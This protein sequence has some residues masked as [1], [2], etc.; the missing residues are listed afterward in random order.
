MGPCGW[1][2]GAHLACFP[3]WLSDPLLFPTTTLLLW[4]RTTYFPKH[5]DFSELC[6]PAEG[7]SM[8]LWHSWEPSSPGLT[9]ESNA[10]GKSSSVM[11]SWPKEVPG[12]W[13]IQ[14]AFRNLRN[15]SSCLQSDFLSV[16]ALFNTC[17]KG[18]GVTAFFFFF[19]YKSFEVPALRGL[20]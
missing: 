5:S 16:F 19:F 4:L 17:G 2:Q 7:R 13:G 14:L 3:S 8:P 1:F 11:P 10:K 9:F 6:P 18:I 12:Q 20:Q 15:A